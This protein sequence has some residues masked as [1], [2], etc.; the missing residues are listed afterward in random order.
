MAEM[1]SRLEPAPATGLVAKFATMPEGRPLT[2]RVT[3]AL[4]LP[5]TPAMVTLVATPGI[6]AV[7]FHCVLS[8]VA[9][10]SEFTTRLTAEEL[11]TVVPAVP[12]T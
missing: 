7:I 12:R 6:A 10:K 11:T 3:G 2:D 9:E 5:P 8:G 4:K 1:V